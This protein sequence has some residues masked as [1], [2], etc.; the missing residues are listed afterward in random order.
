MG[1]V[2][3]LTRVGGGALGEGRGG[4]GIGSGGLGRGGVGELEVEGRQG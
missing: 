1:W 3:G 2:E 4:G